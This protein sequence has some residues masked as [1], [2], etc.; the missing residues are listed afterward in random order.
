LAGATQVNRRGVMPNTS[1]V[2]RPA[3][4]ADDALMAALRALAA[5]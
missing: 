1:A 3:T 5:R 2:D 4:R